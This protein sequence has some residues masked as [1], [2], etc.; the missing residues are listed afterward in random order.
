MRLPTW[1]L[2]LLLA[3]YTAAAADPGSAGA[4]PP[5]L[6]AAAAARFAA[7]ALKCLHEEYPNHLSHTLASDAEARPPRELTPAFYGCYDLSRPKHA[8]PSIRA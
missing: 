1:Q 4:P 7:L 3:G 5:P 8:R 6:E 2:A